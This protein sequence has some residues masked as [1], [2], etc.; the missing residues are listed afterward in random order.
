MRARLAISYAG[1]AVELRE[2]QLRNKP[3]AMLDASPKGTVPVLVLSNG[4]VID[5]SLDIMHWALARND[6]RNWQENQSQALDLIGRN[7]GKFKHYLD[8]YKYADRYPEYPA[9]YY[10]TQGESFL[11]NLEQQLQ[12][13]PFLC[14]PHL[15]LADAAIAPFIRQF[16]AVDNDWFT[17]SPYP[18]TRHW[19]QVFLDS[20][21]F[22]GVMQ[23]YPPWQ[24]GLPA[25]I[26]PHE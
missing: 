11:A 2:V 19:L 26:F 7:D 24:P 9:E 21:L 6:P 12:Q 3:Q 20:A 5:E 17:S 1:I 8:R 10:R 14:G 22:T 13:N 25:T 15:G 4:D 23:N 18:A 16:A